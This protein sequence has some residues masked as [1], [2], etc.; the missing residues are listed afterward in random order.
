MA[1]AM[2][3][4]IP[5]LSPQLAAIFASGR[6]GPPSPLVAAALVSLAETVASGF[7]GLDLPRMNTYAQNRPDCP[8]RF[9][10]EC[11]FPT[12]LEPGIRRWPW[13]ACPH[14][15]K[16]NPANLWNPPTEVGV[17]TS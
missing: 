9:G 10:K 2:A 13:R 15:G 11:F 6:A 12:S 5:Q 16:P 8:N 7:A 3:P 1:D 17:Q 4:A 14:V